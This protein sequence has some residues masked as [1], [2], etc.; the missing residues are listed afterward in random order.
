MGR[1]SNIHEDYGGEFLMAEDIG[2]EDDLTGKQLDVEIA[3]LFSG[4][5]FENKAESK[6]GKPPVMIEKWSLGFAKNGK[7]LKKKLILCKTDYR[8]L[9]WQLGRDTKTWPGKKITLAL[10]WVD[11]FG[12]KNLPVVRVFPPPE[13]MGK[14]PKSVRRFIGRERP[15]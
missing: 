9:Y 7:P 10:R 6:D 15:K 11:A 2:H 8:V 13:L 4:G 5:T 1:M 3:E 12:D 14:L